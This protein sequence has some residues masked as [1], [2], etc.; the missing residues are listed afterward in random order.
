MICSPLQKSFSQQ[1]KSR[2]LDK[3]V[4]HILSCS[5]PLSRQVWTNVFAPSLLRP[6]KHEPSVWHVLFSHLLQKHCNLFCPLLNPVWK[7]IEKISVLHK[8]I[9]Q[10]WYYWVNILGTIFKCTF[11]DVWLKPSSSGSVPLLKLC[12]CSFF[13]WQKSQPSRDIRWPKPRKKPHFHVENRRNTETPFTHACY[14]D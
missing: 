9:H 12:D 4:L 13:V 1:W 10:N 5:G 8:V 3:T 6:T 2:L 11:T 14:W 7:Q